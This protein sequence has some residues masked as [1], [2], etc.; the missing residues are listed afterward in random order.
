MDKII[1]NRMIADKPPKKRFLPVGFISAAAVVIIMFAVARGGPLNLFMKTAQDNNT[2]TENNLN[3]DINNM[4]MH[5]ENAAEAGHDAYYYNYNGNGNGNGDTAAGNAAAYQYQMA[6]P[7]ADE[8]M[9]ASDADSG[10]SA[11]KPKINNDKEKTPAGGAVLTA[12]DSLEIEEAIP[13]AT[14]AVAPRIGFHEFASDTVYA[15][16]NENEEIKES[17]EAGEAAPTIEPPVLYIP[18][19]VEVSKFEPM[20]DYIYEH[21][22]LDTDKIY[23]IYFVSGYDKDNKRSEII[24]NIEVYKTDE[25]YLMFD[26]VDIKDKYILERNLIEN[27]IA[28]GEILSKY[29]DGEYIAVIYWFN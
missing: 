11:V 16:N 5:G 1:E 19:A 26:I 14:E 12:Q 24:K 7:A 25:E 27:N 23:E 15:E 18:G 6:E 21:S 17:G 22:G 29:Q 2:G 10:G 4:A 8:I 28:I 13:E 9:T 3:E 20:E